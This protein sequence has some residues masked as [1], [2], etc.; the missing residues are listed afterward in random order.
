MRGG[1][2]DGGTRYL[3]A[4]AFTELSRA[5]GLGPGIPGCFVA[6]RSRAVGLSRRCAAQRPGAQ[7]RFISFGRV[8]A[9]GPR[10]S[11]ARGALCRHGRYKL[12]LFDKLEAL[13]LA[14]L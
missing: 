1:Q 7:L 12:P 5:Q 2:G 13:C 6:R 8:S 3:A 4:G 11:F 9:R 14:Q 10:I